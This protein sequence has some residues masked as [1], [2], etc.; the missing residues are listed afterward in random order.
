MPDYSDAPEQK[1]A[2]RPE[3]A[4]LPP[5]IGRLANGWKGRNPVLS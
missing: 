1:L 5:D 3:R 2:E 4:G